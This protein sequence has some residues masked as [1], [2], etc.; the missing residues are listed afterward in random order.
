[1][2]SLCVVVIRGGKN[3]FDV[4]F[5]SSWA[6]AFGVVV[7]PIPTLPVRYIVPVLLL[8]ASLVPLERYQGVLAGGV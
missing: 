4:L 2:A 8:P 7:E 3:P 5:T 1:M 6:E